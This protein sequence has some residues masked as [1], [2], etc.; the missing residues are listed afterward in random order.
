VSKSV[1]HFIFCVQIT[2]NTDPV[3]KH[4]T[5]FIVFK[6]DTFQHETFLLCIL[7]EILHYYYLIQHNAEFLLYNAAL[8]RLKCWTSP[9]RLAFTSKFAVS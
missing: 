7:I 1:I 3:S 4:F 8:T 6:S 9:G 5:L 2:Y